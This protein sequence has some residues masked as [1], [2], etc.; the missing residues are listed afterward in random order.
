MFEFICLF[1]SMSEMLEDF[2]G[3][4]YA[5]FVAI[6]L[7]VIWGISISML[8]MRAKRKKA[9]TH[10]MKKWWVWIV[11]IILG[12]HFFFIAFINPTFFGMGTP[13]HFSELY[14]LEDELV[15]FDQRTEYYTD[16]DNSTSIDDYVTYLRIH[17][18]DKATHE[19]KY[20]H[21]IGSDYSTYSDS[22]GFLIITNSTSYGESNN[23]IYAVSTFDLQTKELKTI[24]ENPGTILVD[25]SIYEVYSI[26][27]SNGIFVKT[28][29]AEVFK[30]NTFTQK[31]EAFQENEYV[32][33][34][35]QRAS[36]A[37]YAKQNS[38]DIKELR[39]NN[40]NT[41]FTFL[42]GEI[43]GTFQ[44][45]S[46]A[47]VVIKSYEDLSKKSFRYSCIDDAAALVWEYDLTFFESLFK[48]SGL[49]GIQI[50]KFTDKLC[51]LTFDAYI[52]EME[53]D[54]GKVNWWLKI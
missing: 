5:Q 53:L 3:W 19:K 15:L 18:I 43:F 16:D 2:L 44:N 29:K 50:I 31:F 30:L 45:D 10:Y 27:T 32:S 7:L 26:Y 49:S 12:L 39:I 37:L 42:L 22:T 11:F 23:V 1:S 21:Q 35:Q 4:R 24:V 46:S 40:S 52:V 41:E 13:D 34:T 54:S 20:S 47:Y 38:S 6:G 9:K 8:Q 28:L 14:I 17:V 25:S 33:S 48:T 51:Y 36:F